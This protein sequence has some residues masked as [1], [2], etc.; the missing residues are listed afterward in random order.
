MPHTL[1]AEEC[2]Q[3]LYESALIRDVVALFF[4]ASCID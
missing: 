3:L 1:F 4:T 2:K